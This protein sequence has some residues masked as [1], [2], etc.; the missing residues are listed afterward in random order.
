M[1][2]PSRDENTRPLYLPPVKSVCKSEETVKTE[3]GTTTSFKLEKEDIKAVHCHPAY[4]TYMQ[5]TSCE[6][7]GWMNH[8][9][10]SRIWEKYL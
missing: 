2:N 10:E 5:N 1:G 3:H 4:L 8:K 9:L 6:M 7:L